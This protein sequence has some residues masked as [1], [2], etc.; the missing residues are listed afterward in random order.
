MI[1]STPAFVPPDVSTRDAFF[2]PQ[3]WLLYAGFGSAALGAYGFLSSGKLIMA[4]AFSNNL[5]DIV[6][7]GFT[8]SFVA[9][10]SVAN[11]SG[12]LV[13]PTVSDYLAKW[14]GPQV[15]PFLARK[16][17]QTLMWTLSPLCHLGVVWSVHQCCAQPGPVPLAVFTAST[18]GIL[19]IFG[20]STAQRPAF[21]GDLFGLNSMGVVVSRQLSVV[22][23]S[24]YLG[25]KIVAH[26]RSEATE[27]AV[28]D[29]ATKVDDRDFE[30]AFG[31]G[32]DRLAELLEHK[33]VSIHRLLE[34]MPAGTQ[35]PTPFLYDKAMYILAG[36]NA[37]ALLTNLALSPVKSKTS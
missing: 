7:A 15:D 1:S 22:L 30:L 31:V 2:S 9:G 21:T 33:T 13:F 26:F 23:P 17:V 29:L 14:S 3:F 16:R 36:C 12:R 19:S 4:E 6:T 10:M 34:L 18:F 8:S 37:F 32:K 11:L 24:A 28:R 27:E 20:G 5:P 35:D 25:P